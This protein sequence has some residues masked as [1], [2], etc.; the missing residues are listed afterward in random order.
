MIAL[1]ARLNVAAGKE[2]EFEQ[3]MLEPAAQVRANETG[4]QRYTL[5]KDANATTTR[6]PCLPT[7]MA[8]TSR[9]PGRSSPA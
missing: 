3:A 5:L 6:K 2:V 9:P 8:S 7:A 4:N 1:L